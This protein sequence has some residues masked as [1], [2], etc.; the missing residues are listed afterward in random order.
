VI[1]VLDIDG[2]GWSREG[3]VE[4]ARF[5]NAETVGARVVEGSAYRLAPGGTLYPLR[6]DDRYQL[7][8]V[9]GGRPVALYQ[10]RRYELGPGHGVYCEHGEA[11]G[12]EN[13]T[14]TPAAFYRFV[15]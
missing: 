13:P 8:Y 12:F 15:V 5:L 9:T 14:D 6:E 1:T 2:V 10:G 4:V 11:C 7:F 3:N